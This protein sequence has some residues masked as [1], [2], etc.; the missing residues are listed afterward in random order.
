[1][2][3]LDAAI[4]DVKLKYLDEDG[5][6]Q[7]Y[8]VV[9]GLQYTNGLCPIIPDKIEL[10]CNLP[11]RLLQEQTST[12]RGSLDRHTIS[13]KDIEPGEPIIIYTRP[14]NDTTNTSLNRTGGKQTTIDSFNRITKSKPK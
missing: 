1:M 7:Y 2:S 8:A 12:N 10:I 11:M 5:N 4:L 3:E 9:H 14:N 13:N 6:T